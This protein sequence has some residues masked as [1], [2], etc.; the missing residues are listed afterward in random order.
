MNKTDRQFSAFRN[1]PQ[2]LF[3]ANETLTATEQNFQQQIYLRQ[4][5]GT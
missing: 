3:Y 4:I 5:S 1:K 2:K